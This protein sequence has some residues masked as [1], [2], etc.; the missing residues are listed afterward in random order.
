VLDRTTH[1]LPTSQVTLPG[2][3]PPP[4]QATVVHAAVSIFHVPPEQVAS[5]RPVVEQL[6]KKQ[7]WSTGPHVVPWVGADAGQVGA[8]HAV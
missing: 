2:V 6:S 1:A 8:G 5:V 7:V 4:A 3:M